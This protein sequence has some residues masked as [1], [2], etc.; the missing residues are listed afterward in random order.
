MDARKERGQLI[1]ETCKLEC[2]HGVWYVPSQSGAS[3]YLVRMDPDL[4]EATERG[5]LSRTPHFN[6][7]FNY[8]E[9]PHVTD[10]LRSLLTQTAL[11]LKSVELDFACD[12]SGFMT[13][14]FDRW[15]DQKYGA[16]KKKAR[17]VKA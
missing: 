17:W 1:A 11:L 5:Y 3:R 14:R 9:N 8:L 12:S 4:P 2:R 6:S 16:P 10:I 13:S 7:I 15:F